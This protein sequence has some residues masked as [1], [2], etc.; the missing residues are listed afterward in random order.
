MRK[1]YEARWVSRQRYNTLRRSGRLGDT[2]LLETTNGYLVVQP[3][4]SDAGDGAALSPAEA[5]Y[6]LQS[7]WFPGPP[8]VLRQARGMLGLETDAGSPRLA[9]T[10]G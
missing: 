2:L 1:Q 10:S 3:A 8:P 4:G 9:E 6:E 5:D 7:V